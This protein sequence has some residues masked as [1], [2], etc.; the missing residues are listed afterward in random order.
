MGNKNTVNEKALSQE[1]LN[2]HSTHW[3]YCPRCYLIPAIKPFLMKG[4]LY[5]SL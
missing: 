2:T 1:Y 5:I 3:M 4:E